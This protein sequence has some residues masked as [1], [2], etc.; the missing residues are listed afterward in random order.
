MLEEHYGKIVGGITT[1][2]VTGAL[3]L[4]RI[5]M[6]NN[7]RIAVLEANEISRDKK[8]EEDTAMQKEMRHDIKTILEKL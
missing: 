6:G 8:R 7:R 3:W 1:F 4:V 2:F 5:I